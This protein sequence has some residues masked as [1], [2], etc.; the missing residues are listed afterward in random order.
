VL[1][2]RAYLSSTAAVAQK[3]ELSI[4]IPAYNE[5]SRLPRT[6]EAIE[7]YL[8][9]STDHVEVIVVDDGSGDETGRLID[10][11]AETDDRVTPVHLGTNRGKGRALAEG[12]VRSSG[13][14]V[15]VTDA[16]LSAPISELP[17]LEAAI[18]DGA[19]IAIASRAVRGAQI[20]VSQ[21]LYRV[22]MGKAYNLLVQALLLPG[23]W[24]TQCGFKLFRGDV[25]RRLFADLGH[26]GFGCDVEVLYRARRQ[27]ARIVEVPVRW[28]H[29]APT[30]VS[31]LRHSVEMLIDLFRIRLGR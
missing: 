25:G 11:V 3:V 15:L 5:A 20:E 8:D 16:D 22:L 18:T 31:T 28:A 12:V 7:R 2:D 21:P 17:K 9:G 29:S 13:A 14:L 24:D 6:L 10:H 19:D 26:D 27:G 4:V 1:A 23:L 30:R